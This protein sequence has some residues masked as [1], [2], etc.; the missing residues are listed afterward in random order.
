MVLM[1][2]ATLFVC[3]SLIR[4][5]EEAVMTVL[6]VP[7]MKNGMEDVDRDSGEI[8][9]KNKSILYDDSLDRC[10]LCGVYGHT[11]EHHI[12]GGP[13]RKASDRLGLVVHLCRTCHRNVHE[14][15]SNMMLYLHQKGQIVYE[16]HIG[17][18]Q[19]FIKE[20]IKSYL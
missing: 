5:T 6:S 4:A 15:N 16:E 13:C 12:F 1:I 10:Y 2:T 17:S 11:D 19:E 9:S 7:S 20:F 3:I 8:M 18:R 14:K